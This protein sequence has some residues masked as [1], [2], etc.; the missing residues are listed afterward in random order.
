MKILVWT[1]SV[2]LAVLVVGLAFVYFSPDYDMYT[3]RSESMSP[4]LKIGDMLFTGPVNGPFGG[5][6]QPGTIVT[7]QKNGELVTHRIISLENGVLIAKGDANADPDQVPVEAASIKGVMLFNV[8][9]AGYMTGFIRTKLGWFL[10]ILL[11]TALL[12]GWL[13]MDILKEAFRSDGAKVVTTKGAGTHG[14]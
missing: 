1:L 12:A 9:L 4:A 3:V 2:I 13:I 7:Y 11:P 10:V 14:K 5:G 8:P 6:I